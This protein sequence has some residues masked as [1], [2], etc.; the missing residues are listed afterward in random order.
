MKSGRSLNAQIK[1][2]YIITNSFMRHLI[3]SSKDSHY[4]IY[5]VNPLSNCVFHFYTVK[6][7]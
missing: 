3:C 6:T 1:K 5:R 7:F 2:K 4:M